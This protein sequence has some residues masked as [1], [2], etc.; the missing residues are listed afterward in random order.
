MTNKLHSKNITFV[1]AYKACKSSPC[2]NGAICTE[3]TKR[4]QCACTGYYTGKNCESESL[5]K[6]KLIPCYSSNIYDYTT[7]KFYSRRL[8]NHHRRPSSGTEL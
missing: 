6:Y 1:V 5:A 3:M 4:Y 2:M 8:F 7:S